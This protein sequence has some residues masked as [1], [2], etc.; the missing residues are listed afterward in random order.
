MNEKEAK[1]EIATEKN[2][3]RTLATPPTSLAISVRLYVFRL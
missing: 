1:G 3:K 2:S